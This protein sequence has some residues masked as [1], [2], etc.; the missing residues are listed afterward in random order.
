VS[1][2][3]F[4]S[5]LQLPP[6]YGGR[7]GTELNATSLLEGTFSKQIKKTNARGKPES[8]LTVFLFPIK[9]FQNLRLRKGLTGKLL[10]LPPMR[11]YHCLL[12][13]ARELNKR[14]MDGPECG[15]LS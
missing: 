5:A 6:G 10:G 3:P 8:D 2:D 4:P 14:V 9:S 11:V 7:A 15:R 12:E 1:A 13:P